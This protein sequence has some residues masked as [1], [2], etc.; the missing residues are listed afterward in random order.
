MLE[1]TPVRRSPLDAFALQPLETTDASTGLQI[2]EL[3]G[4][5]HINIRLDASERASANA[6]KRATG[7]AVPKPGT[8]EASDAAYLAWLSPDEFLLVANAP[9]TVVDAATLSGKLSRVHHAVNDVSSGQTIVRMSGERA[10]HV[11]SKGCTLDL[12]A[13]VFAPPMCANTRIAKTHAFL[14]VVEPAVFDVIVRR[15]FAPYFWSWL[16]KACADSCATCGTL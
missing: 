13:S 9:G 1:T 6:L 10:A 8:Y 7:L 14:R 16:M 5:T 3:P 4:R 15:S 11:L 2:A 12:H